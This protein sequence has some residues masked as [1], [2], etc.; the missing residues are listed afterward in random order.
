MSH[1]YD[2][3]GNLPDPLPI[4]PLPATGHGRVILPGSKSLTNRALMIAALGKGTTTLYGAL[5]SRDTALMVTALRELGFQVAEDP[6][7][8]TFRIEG[9]G[10]RIS[11]ARASLFTGLSGTATRFLAALVALHPDGEYTFDGDPVMR[12]RPVAGLLQALQAQ[13]TRVT[14]HGEHD[15]L[16]CT[17]HT[18]GLSGGEFSVDASASSQILSA[19]LMAAP[20]ARKATTLNAP[21]VRP[22]FVELTTQLMARMGG[23]AITY[24]GTHAR[25]PATGPYKTPGEFTIEPDLTAASYFLALPLATGGRVLLPHIPAQPMQGD[26]AF[27]DILRQHGLAITHQDGAWHSRPQPPSQVSPHTRPLSTHPSRSTEKGMPSEDPGPTPLEHNFRTFSD[28]FLT[29]GALT[30]LLSGPITLSGLTHTRQQETDR[31]AGLAKELRRLGQKVIETEDT[32]TLTPNRAKLQTLAREARAQGR[33]LTIETYED[34]R[35]AMAF[36]ILGTHDL[37]G[38]NQP[39]LALQDP[40]CCSKTYPKFFGELARME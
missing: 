8:H 24:D 13:G 6:A 4:Q 2:Q 25:I 5:F 26:A 17:L 40:A 15:H 20:L 39:W 33:L 30:P 36:G 35:F 22:A 12:T 23:P 32:L 34:H 21:G 28:T 1:P 3:P 11:K 38:D 19:L 18:S 9:Q 37:L 29:L 31:P 10:G 7:R 27:L 14:F 16:P